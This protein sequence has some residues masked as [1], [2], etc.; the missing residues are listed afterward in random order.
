MSRYNHLRISRSFLLAII[1]LVIVF[2]APVTAQSVLKIFGQVINSHGA[3]SNV[4]VV[5]SNSPYEAVTDGNGYYRF[6]DIPPGKYQ[7]ICY[8]ANT[9]LSKT[10]V[11][12]L[13]DG[14]AIRQDIYL[15]P[16]IINIEAVEIEADA[17]EKIG[18]I[19]ESARVY[20]INQGEVRSIEDIIERVPGLNLVKSTA[21]GEAYI[22]AGGSRPEG[23][24]VLLDGIKMNSL[25]TGRADINQLPLKA[26]TKVEY[27]ST[28][29]GKYSSDG[30]IS[31]TVNFVT[32][33]N[34]R[35]ELF[36]LNVNRGSY[37][38]EDYSSGISYEKGM[39]GKI[40]VIAEF[41]YSRNDFK[42]DH[43]LFGE[44]TRE[45]AYARYNKYYLSYT[46]SLGNNDLSLTGYYYIGSNGVP[47]KIT[48]PYFEAVSD[49]NSGT[50]GLKLSRLVSKSFKLEF[51]SS[52]KER[53]SDYEDF[54][55][56]V[57]FNTSYYEREFEF[58]VNAEQ[59]YGLGISAVQ[60]ISFTNGRLV[61]EDYIR[62]NQALGE[63]YRD[64]YKIHGG[65][66]YHK[67]INK[68]DI[69]T[70]V[71]YA[72]SGVNGNN[73]SSG[74]VGGTVALN[75]PVRIGLASSYS[76]AYRLPGLAE[77]HWKEDVFVVPA[78]ST[79]LPEKSNSISTELFSEFSLLG[80]WRLSSEYKDI[81][82]TDLIYW[83]RSIG[84][85]YKPQNISSSDYFG[86][87]LAA[88]YQSPGDYLN[89]E[90]SRERS[91]PLNREE[92]LSG[93]Y[94]T[95][96]PLYANRLKLKLS[97]SRAFVKTEMLDIS[98]RYF[99]EANT[100]K[101]NPYTLVNIGLGHEIVFGKL[102]AAWLFEINNVTDATYDH[103]E[104]QPGAPRSYHIGVNFK[105]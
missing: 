11:I 37:N 79:L 94:I 74:S 88:F 67:A 12:N 100:K 93:N 2:A 75:L 101:L 103:L 64:V 52:F 48:T 54:G 15:D 58:K 97:Y 38:D 29:T 4:N 72:H 20:Q 14:P 71:S 45:N 80:K 77:L 39:L 18:Y 56:W 34:S 66:N 60:T 28:S 92:G 5:I 13:I 81:R 8:M 57:P 6:Y 89:F 98:E 50:L 25:L 84:D 47:G 19:G 62:P 69:N 7:L 9:R 31:G 55:S 46:N 83:R 23:V 68:L 35:P 42:Y 87:I 59:E 1:I 33:A 86:I 63:C 51:A 99:L 21:T 30:G 61:G 22:S 104:Y 41:G 32:K 40:R 70:G 36:D 82:Y 85:R 76:H 96:Q 95:F 27:Y 78:D 24:N 91:Y 102:T 105:M 65:L 3:V 73:Y 44:Q 53:N 49:K 26:I 90:F 17:P 16:G 43:D 10:G